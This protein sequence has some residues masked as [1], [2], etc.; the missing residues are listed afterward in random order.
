MSSAT[1]RSSSGPDE[2][3]AG[4]GE[5]V[6]AH[7]RREQSLCLLHV[8]VPG[9]DDHVDTLDGLGAVG[10][11]GDRLRPAHA[12]DALHAAETADAQD[13]RIDLPVSARRRADGHVQHAGGAGGHHAHHDRARIG[14]AAARH[15]HGRRGDRHLAQRDPLPLGQIHEHVLTDPR[16]GDESDVCDG[17]LQARHEL[18][19]E[20]ADRIVELLR[21]DEKG[22]RVVAGGVESAR[23]VPDGVLAL[24]ADPVEDLAHGLLDRVATRDERAQV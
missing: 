20:Q 19:R 22:L 15:I 14:R 17:H 24:G 4:T 5:A 16:L 23:V 2:Q 10:E 1:S 21:C 13:D 9:A 8:Q 7:G 6:D 18:Q 3:I 11:R 12:V